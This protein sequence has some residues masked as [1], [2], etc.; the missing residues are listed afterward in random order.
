M[1]LVINHEKANFKKTTYETKV[2]TEG[3]CEDLD[4]IHLAQD[5]VQL[6]IC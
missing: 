2:Y 3:W 6:Q 5:S 4:W 1:E